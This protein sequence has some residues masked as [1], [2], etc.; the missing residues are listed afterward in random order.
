MA[1]RRNSDWA[2]AA[3]HAQRAAELTR[4]PFLPGD[5]GPWVDEM[6]SAQRT[7]LM[8]TLDVFIRTAAQPAPTR[9]SLST[10]ADDSG[11]WSPDGL[12]VAWAGQRRKVMLRGAGA[13]QVSIEM[14]GRVIALAHCP[15]M[16]V[17]G[18]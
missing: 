14:D 3:G 13:G 4:R 16:T 9:L 5:E 7:L 8:R 18:K 6:R 15:V 2:D 10:D 12:R 11:V 1:R 17:R